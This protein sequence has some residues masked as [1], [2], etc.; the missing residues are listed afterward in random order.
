MYKAEDL[1]NVFLGYCGENLA[2]PIEIDCTCMVEGIP[3]ASV[4]VLLKR[5][6]DENYY[7]VV[8]DFDG[9]I[10]RFLPN[11]GLL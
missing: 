5:H 8:I 3:G 6:K 7:P 11:N 1:Q 4:A 9:R 10:A 2:R